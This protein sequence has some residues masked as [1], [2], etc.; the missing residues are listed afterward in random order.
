MAKGLTLFNE[1]Q[2][3][4]HVTGFLDEEANIT[5]RQ[6]VNALGVSGKVFSISLN[7]E[8]KKVTKRDEDGEEVPVSV[9]PVVILDYAK[10][11]GRSYYEGGY[12]P[13]ATKAPVCWSEDSVKPDPSVQEPQCKTCA[14]CPMAVKGSKITD[15]NKATVQCGPYRMVVVAP[16]RAL[17][18]PL[19]LKLAVTSDFDGDNKEN[20]A[21]G[22]FAFRQYT[23]ML[24]S[25]S[26]KHT[27]ALVTVLKFDQNR[28]YPKLLFSP[29][30]WLEA[31]EL[32]A[33]KSTLASGEI[34]R[35][36]KGFTPDGVDGKAKELPAPKHEPEVKKAKA[37]PA[38]AD[39]EDDED[40]APAK[41]AK[42]KA[43]PAPADDED[44]EDV[45]PPPKKAAAKAAPK[46]KPPVD[47]EDDEDVAPAP[48]KAKAQDV[49]AKP[50][51]AS[52][53]VPDDVKQ[54]VEDWD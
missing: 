10:N 34:E 6:S 40:T 3:P 47:D 4:A 12:D 43:K 5:D 2:M 23:D 22:Y 50:A 28:E 19:R 13:N 24:R 32:A 31:E 17:D 53:S 41:P 9:L 51:K 35:L 7:G 18:T 49:D 54:L 14:E 42:A 38:P 15:A 33:V 52:T 29:R 20:E 21:K 48:K 11:R 8:T 46:A 37:K 44:D 27:A 25:R 1:N 45:A 26:V 36:L 30:R 16:L 39:D